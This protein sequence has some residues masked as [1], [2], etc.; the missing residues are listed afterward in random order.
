MREIP[1]FG[2]MH[3]AKH[4][5]EAARF[6]LGAS[7]V[8]SPGPEDFTPVEP[9]APFTSAGDE[10][11]APA[12]RRALASAHGV[13]EDHVLL[14]VGTSLANFNA[15]LALAGPGDRVLV[16]APTYPS[17]ADIPRVLGLTT[18]RLARRPEE[19]WAP[20]L[21]DIEAA[22]VASGPPLGLVVLTRLHNPSGRDLPAGFLQKLASLADRHGF[23]VMVDEVYL[24]FLPDATPAHR[25]SARFVSTGSLTKAWGFG[26]LRIGWIVGDPSLLSR[27]REASY[28]L[29]VNDA[30]WSQDVAA[31]ALAARERL[32]GRSRRIAADGLA[33]F[34]EWIDR[35]DDL[36]WSAPDGGLVAFV[37]AKRIA[38]TA[39]FAQRLQRERDVAIAEGELFGMPGWFRVCWGAPE[40]VV[41]EGLRRLGEALDEA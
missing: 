13:S 1:T 34:R 30:A 21:E 2:L 38:D 36:E 15:I 24:D 4:R 31:Q 6:S 20:R 11:G 37:R 14:S 12:L 23:R 16:E 22:A 18:D 29:A 5:S 28:Y 27:A 41:R 25:V 3:W 10:Y 8:S 33:I 26:G 7:G 39:S 40:G 17:L 19:G 32:L 35:R 9:A